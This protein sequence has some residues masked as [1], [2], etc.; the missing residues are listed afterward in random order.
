MSQMIENLT[1]IQAEIL[2]R[3]QHPSLKE[4]DVLTVNLL[5][6]EPIHGKTDLLS[7]QVGNT[8]NLTVRR[9]L[10]DKGQTGDKLYCRASRSFDGAMC[11]PFPDLENF[12]I[13]K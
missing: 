7:P 13:D 9:E 11:E 2:A 3:S 10:L 5:K 4:Y 6:A 1:Q 12:R 8:L